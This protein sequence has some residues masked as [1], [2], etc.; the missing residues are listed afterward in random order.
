[1]FAD[2]PAHPASFSE[3][4]QLAM[5]D[6]LSRHGWSQHN[7]F[8]PQE[9]TLLL[10]AECR[11]LTEDGALVLAAVGRGAT[12]AVRPGIRGDRI[13]WLHAG[14]SPACDRYLQIMEGVRVSLNRSLYLGLDEYESHFAFYAPGAAYHKHLDRFQDDDC[15]TVS[16]VIYLNQDWLP[17]DGGAL[18]LHPE[19]Q[20]MEDIAPLGSRMVL[21]LSADM[22]HEVLPATR[23]RISLAG[24]FRRRPS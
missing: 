11:V 14:Q 18:R 8:L 6:N 17:A 20:C 16:V 2:S 9:L 15:R 23:D 24:W 3:A 5:A 10:E 21:F 7:I 12:Q 19:G 1:M 13:R 4:Q 22:L